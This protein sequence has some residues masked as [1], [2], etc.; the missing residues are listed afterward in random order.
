MIN[1]INRFI[2]GMAVPFPAN[3]EKTKMDIV[4]C[5]SCGA[6]VEVKDEQM[7]AFCNYCGSKSFDRSETNFNAIKEQVKWAEDYANKS[8]GMMTS[9]FG[10]NSNAL[11]GMMKSLGSKM[12]GKDNKSIEKSLEKM[13]NAINLDDEEFDDDED[14]D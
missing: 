10:I 4:K 14:D 5:P 6:N 7:R 3:K 8:I 2:F 9:F 12:T 1:N 11:D 13:L